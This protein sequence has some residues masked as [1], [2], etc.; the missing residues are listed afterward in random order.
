MK[1]TGDLPDS[2]LTQAKATVLERERSP[3]K[4]FH[5]RD[6]SRR[7]GQPPVKSWPEIRAIIYDGRGE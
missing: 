3:A 6:G 1:T 7:L 2:L 5:L 4:P